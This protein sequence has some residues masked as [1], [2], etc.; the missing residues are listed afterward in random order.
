MARLAAR[1]HGVAG[2]RQLLKL[3]FTPKAID[4]RVKCGRLHVIHRGVY[5]VGH[6]ALTFK[7]ELMAALLACGPGGLVSHRTATW[8][9]DLRPS[10]SRR[11]ELTAARS[12]V[13]ITGVTLHRPRRLHPEDRAT[14]DGFPVTSVA[15]TL[16]DF[17]STAKKRE[18]ERAYE[19]AERIQVLDRYKLRQAL[20]RGPNRPGTKTIRQVIA[21]HHPETIHTKEEFERRFFEFC[22]TLGF[23]DPLFNA[24]VEGYMVDAYWPDYALIVELDS[25]EHH[26]GRAA[27]EYDHLK[28]ARLESRGYRVVPLTWKM[29]TRDPEGTAALLQPHFGRRV[30]DTA[31]R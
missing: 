28:K 11:I 25:W 13:H 16:I 22:R 29:L 27:F 9:W 24:S 14:K 15:R 3:G 10:S 4:F 6:R 12:R 30:K 8:L 1:Q 18:V 20:D 19:Q 23:P 31:R 5:A 21:E 17:A 7:G 2:R 26:G